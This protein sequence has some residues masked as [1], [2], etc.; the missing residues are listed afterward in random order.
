MPLLSFRFL[1]GALRTVELTGTETIAE[2]RARF[3]VWAR[4]PW[5]S[6]HS[7]RELVVSV[8]PPLCSQGAALFAESR[9][10]PDAATV[11][12]LNLFAGSGERPCPWRLWCSP[13]APARGLTHLRARVGVSLC[14]LVCASVQTYPS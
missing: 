8:P 3:G 12:S 11:N 6:L 7:W 9:L 4:T 13:I 14:P 2:L 1:D 5:R 10:L